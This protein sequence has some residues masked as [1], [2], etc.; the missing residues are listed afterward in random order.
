MTSKLDERASPPPNPN[1]NP[2]SP[3]RKVARNPNSYAINCVFNHNCFG[4]TKNKILPVARGNMRA[5][6]NNCLI[7]KNM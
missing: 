5:K 7:M 3:D 2:I 6:I 4:I 1:P